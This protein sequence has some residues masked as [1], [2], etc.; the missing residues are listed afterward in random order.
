MLL[1]ML[2]ATM[3]ECLFL[4]WWEE[5]VVCSCRYLHRAQVYSRMQEHTRVERQVL[6]VCRTCE[7][8]CLYRRGVKLHWRAATLR[9]YRAVYSSLY[10][11]IQLQMFSDKKCLMSNSCTKMHLFRSSSYQVFP[12]RCSVEKVAIRGISWVSVQCVSCTVAVSSFKE[13]FK[14]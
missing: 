4:Q 9:V 12:D 14:L 7:A 6:A 10:H 8:G 3:W 5:W 13:L 1:L 2:Q 11:V